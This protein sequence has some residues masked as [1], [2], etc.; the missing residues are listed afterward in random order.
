MFT[1]G[2]SGI[3]GSIVATGALK[4]VFDLGGVLETSPYELEDG[5]KNWMLFAPSGEVLSYRGDG[6]YHWGPANIAETEAD[7]LPLALS[8]DLG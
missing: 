4:F 5:Y 2:A 1:Y 3:S 8:R 7:W 6:R